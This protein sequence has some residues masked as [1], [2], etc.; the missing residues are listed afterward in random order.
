MTIVE[1][2]VRDT[3]GSDRIRD[4]KTTLAVSRDGEQVLRVRVVYDETMGQLDVDTLMSV[5]DRLC[6][7]EPELPGFPVV[8]FVANADLEPLLAAE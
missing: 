4:V 8:S 5:T 2:I 6:D 7:A 1:K 3:L